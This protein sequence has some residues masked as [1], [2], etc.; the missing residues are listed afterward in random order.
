MMNGWWESNGRST[1]NRDRLTGQMTQS[2]TSS[3]AG[4]SFRRVP[5]R[6][7]PLAVAILV[8]LAVA[9]WQ[10]GW[11]IQVISYGDPS[12]TYFDTTRARAGDT[13]HIHFDGLTWVRICKSRLIQ[14]VTCQQADPRDTN[15]TITAR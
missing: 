11:N 9:I 8:P 7:W 14:R 15:K 3:A 13:I 1:S 12:K 10:W 2:R 4:V 5:E 6:R